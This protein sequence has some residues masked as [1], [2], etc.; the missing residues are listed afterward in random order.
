MIKISD[1]SFIEALNRVAASD[2]GKIILAWLKNA[3]HWDATIMS[4]DPI[5][6]QQYA[7]LRGVWSKVRQY[8]KISHLK[9]IEFDYQIEKTEVKQKAG[10]NDRPSTTTNSSK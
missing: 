6:T 3:C 7:A 2:D 1:K 9:E 5:I 10:K 4:T 8:I